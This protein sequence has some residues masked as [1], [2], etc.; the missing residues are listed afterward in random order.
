MSRTVSHLIKLADSPEFAFALRTR[1]VDGS[2][3][4]TKEAAMIVNFQE[5]NWHGHRNELA[6]LPSRESKSSD[7]A[8]AWSFAE[9]DWQDILLQEDRDTVSLSS[10]LPTELPFEAQPEHPPNLPT[11]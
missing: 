11:E 1:I 9:V 4:E 6:Q 8:G 10:S 2:A 3:A 7:S 5:Q